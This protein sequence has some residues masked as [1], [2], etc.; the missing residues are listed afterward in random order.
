[1]DDVGIIWNALHLNFGALNPSLISKWTHMNFLRETLG[2]DM[3]M[4][5]DPFWV[6]NCVKRTRQGSRVPVFNVFSSFMSLHSQRT[7][8][9]IKPDL[10]GICYMILHTVGSGLFLWAYFKNQ[11]PLNQNSGVAE[12]RGKPKGELSQERTSCQPQDNVARWIHLAGSSK[13]QRCTGW[14]S[15]RSMGMSMH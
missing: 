2:G 7:H 5:I 8:P 12:H 9:L 13:L 11:I 15:H 1:M 4:A 14:A 3:P 6:R 10:K